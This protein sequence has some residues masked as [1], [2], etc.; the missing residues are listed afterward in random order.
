MFSCDSDIDNPRAADP[1]WPERPTVWDS[2]V[3]QHT[4]G[5]A[6]LT[7]IQ[8]RVDRECVMNIKNVIVMAVSPKKKNREKKQ[9]TKRQHPKWGKEEEAQGR[10][11]RTLRTRPGAAPGQFPPLRF[12]V[13]FIFFL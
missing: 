5:V 12:A 2:Q 11:T 4:H 9:K 7:C 1:K 13:V 10:E 6:C 8:N 3:T